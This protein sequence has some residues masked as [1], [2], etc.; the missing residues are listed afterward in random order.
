MFKSVN[1]FQMAVL[2]LILVGVVM[3]F[4]RQNNTCV[5]KQNKTKEGFQNGFTYDDSVN[6]PTYNGSSDNYYN[7]CKA[8][9]KAAKCSN[10]GFAAA[11][12]D[13]CRNYLEIY[14][15]NV[16]YPKYNNSSD[17]YYNFCKAG[18]QAGKCSK[19][20][21]AAACRDECIPQS[22]NINIPNN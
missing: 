1:V 19:P 20:G 10:P 13:E 8:G 5:M 21:F 16:Y 9:Q 18:Q 7:F 3:I 15:N 11:C 17:N 6:Y 2:V 12:R 22:S 4:M 14:E